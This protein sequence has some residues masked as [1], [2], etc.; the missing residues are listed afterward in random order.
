MLPQQARADTICMTPNPGETL[1]YT[2]GVPAKLVNDPNGPG[3][4]V[5]VGDSGGT[6]V[7]QLQ[8]LYRVVV[9]DSVNYLGTEQLVS[10]VNDIRNAPSGVTF[11]S[12][13]VAQGNPGFIST[14]SA[15][16]GT[17]SYSV[18]GGGSG[19]PVLTTVEV[20]NSEIE[21][22][23][24]QRR[25]LGQQPEV[26][27][28]SSDAATGPTYPGPS[29]SVAAAKNSGSS[30]ARGGS[31]GAPDGQDAFASPSSSNGAWGQVFADYERKENLAPGSVDNPTRI[32]KTFGT[33]SGYDITL[34][35]FAGDGHESLKLGLLG[36]YVNTRSDFS[37][38]PN[39][40]DARQRQDGAFVG[41][42]AAYQLNNFALDVLFKADFLEYRSRAT[43]TATTSARTCP[44]GQVLVVDRYGDHLAG[45]ETVS[46]SGEVDEF[47]YTI[48][49]NAYYR[50]DLGGGSWFEPVAGIRFSYT[51][52]GS[53][54]AALGLD[55]G[56][57]LRVQG[58]ARIGQTWNDTVGRIW[59][60]SLL[61]L[62]YSD[63][64]INGFTLDNTGFTSTAS[65]VDEGKLRVLGQLAG[66]VDVGGGW[67][68]N[69]QIE[70]RGGEDL[71]G[72]G[73]R[74]GLRLEW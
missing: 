19:P 33:V 48:G 67:S 14:G 62:L 28:A 72:V 57:Q 25:E 8:Q 10:S 56:E 55:N 43:T 22:L 26:Q 7:F 31:G 34:N 73:G 69:G 44:A 54:A 36:G 50:F 60:L 65:E 71:V 51:D 4:F 66:N 29:G 23:I 1:T 45:L 12:I 47:T 35:R 52:Y 49:G 5:Y 16:T 32:Q 24:R 18:T 53:G 6:P 61:G 68:Y 30:E 9:T 41:A 13:S 37:D 17:A 70:V 2:N 64:Y 74:L 21:D 59:S 27:V 63:V 46:T 3:G 58:G 38:T 42:Y 20:T 11:R 39:V 15:T 40:T